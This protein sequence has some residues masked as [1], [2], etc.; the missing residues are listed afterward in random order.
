MTRPL[1]IAFLAGAALAAMAAVTATA[2]SAAETIAYRYDARG[3]L[4]EVK[5]T[6]NGSGAPAPTTTAYAFDKADNRTAKTTSSP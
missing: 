1:K 4:I 5:R 3:R 2:A 6:T